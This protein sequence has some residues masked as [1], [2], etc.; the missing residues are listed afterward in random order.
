MPSPEASRRNLEKAKENWRP[1]RRWRSSQEAH[2]IK[3]MVWQWFTY[4]APRKLSG[5]AM[6]RQLGI[7]HTYIQK[8]VREFKA[9]PSEMQRQRSYGEATFGDL[10][11]AQEITRQER[12]RGHL[13]SRR[14]RKIPKF[15]VDDN[16]VQ[17]VVPTKARTMPE[18]EARAS[19]AK[20]RGWGG[21]RPGAGRKRNPLRELRTHMA[22]RWI[23]PASASGREI[24]LGKSIRQLYRRCAGMPQ[25]Q[26]LRAQILKKW[27]QFFCTCKRHG[28]P[29]RRTSAI[30][31]DDVPVEIIVRDL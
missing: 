16:V 5:R 10:S 13:R 21:A 1:P 19:R 3:L 14:P 20:G 9:N 23:V 4:R 7:S 30:G 31:K 26:R 18:L 27:P 24:D 8:L 22:E 15:K 25:F 28:K 17:G 6:A 11:R 12:A 2:V 29:L